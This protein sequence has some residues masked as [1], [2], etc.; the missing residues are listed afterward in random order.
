[1]P[2]R[3]EVCLGP[4]DIVFD[5]DPAP[6]KKGTAPQF[7][8]HLYCGHTAGWIM[9]SLVTEVNL[10]PGGVVLDGVAAPPKRAHP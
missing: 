10:G 4:D 8:A 3:M 5:V 9:M 2:L 7:S 1:M 6:P